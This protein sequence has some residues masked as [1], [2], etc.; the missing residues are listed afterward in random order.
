[1]TLIATIGVETYPAIFGGLVVPETSQAG[2]ERTIPGTEQK[3]V[4][5]GDH[6]VV[7]WDGD[8]EVAR[9]VVSEL[10]ALASKAPLSTDLITAYLSHLDPATKDEFSLVGW[11]KESSV[12]H[13][14]WYRADIA[15]SAMFGRISAGG[16][17]AAA[18]ATLAS[19]IS[20]GSE[21]IGGEAQRGLDRAISSMLSAT[22][23]LLQAEL[24][25]AGDLP[26]LADDGCEI[27]TFVGDRFA[28]LGDVT[29]VFWKVEPVDG[30]VLLS[31]PD[32]IV[33]QDYAG[34]SLLLHALRIRPGKAKADPT[35]VEEVKHVIPPFGAIVDE[36]EPADISWPGMDATF[37]CHMVVARSPN[38]LVVFNQVEYSQSRTPRSIRFSFDNNQKNP[39]R[40][41][42]K[43]CAEL[44]QNVREGL[45]SR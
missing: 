28:K 9:G 18:F 16:S 14:F 43:F 40:V 26:R 31:G 39:F 17:A 22:S 15:Q 35:V 3:I 37:T 44:L 19:Q 10:R 5:L 11:A 42:Q 6:C 36:A 7:A 24:S 34:E 21:N 20:G 4:L 38:N 12:F 2:S 41:N 33:K 25:S 30:E 29:F 13:Q 23:L 27:A 8:V 1:M 32:L 45:V